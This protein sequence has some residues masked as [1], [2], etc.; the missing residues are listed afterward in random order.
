MVNASRHV[1]DFYIPSVPQQLNWHVVV[2]TG[3]EPSDDL[4]SPGQEALW[5]NQKPID[6]RRFPSPYRSIVQRSQVLI[7]H[8]F[9]SREACEQISILS[10]APA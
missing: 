5:E 9:A 2:D 1:P 8:V 3:Q 7:D 4:V 10:C 6:L